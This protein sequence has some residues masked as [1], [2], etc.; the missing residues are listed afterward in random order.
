VGAST[1]ITSVWTS[2]NG[3]RCGTGDQ[4]QLPAPNFS[5][6]PTAATIDVRPWPTWAPVSITPGHDTY[7]VAVFEAIY[8]YSNPTYVWQN[9]RSG[10]N[11][12]TI[13]GQ[14]SPTLA[15][16]P[17]P[18]SFWSDG[19][20]NCSLLGNYTPYL[21]APTFTVNPPAIIDVRPWVAFYTGADGRQWLETNGLNRSSWYR[22]TANAQGPVQWTTPTG[23]INPW[24]WAPI[25]VSAGHGTRTRSVPSPSPPRSLLRSQTGCRDRPAPRQS[26]ATGL[27]CRCSRGH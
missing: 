21:V 13:L 24:T 20:L 3:L 15:A 14:F 26:P 22:W 2:F 7:L 9:A 17:A 11:A 1:P 8:W 18:L 6:E 25:R 12:Q 5:S 10:P 19:G 4:A 23:S 27:R 16:K